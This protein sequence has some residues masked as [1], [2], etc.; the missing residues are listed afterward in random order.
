MSRVKSAALAAAP[1]LFVVLWS[2]GFIGTKG[3]ARNADPFAFLALRFTIAAG[4]MGLLTALLRAPWPTRGQ[5]GRAAVTG[6]LLH[7]GYLG[8]VT[9]AIWLGLPAGITSVLVGVQPLLT[10]G[11]SWPVLGERVTSRQWAGLALGFVGVL[12]VVEG[13]VGAGGSVGTGAVVAAL[14]ALACTTAGT[15]YQR[16]VGADMPLLG[17]TT[18]QYVAS[19]AALGLVT[20]A[21]GGG[22][23]HWTTEF[24]V[25]LTWL[26][27]VL[28]VGAILLLMTLLRDL[29]AARV[30]S[31]FYLVPPLA[32]LET[33]LLYGERLSAASLAGLALCVAGVA[34]AAAPQP[35]PALARTS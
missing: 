6:L 29:P 18:A 21:R 26:V 13:R 20:L 23:V 14:V 4:L 22:E 25:S 19:A 30:G 2:T 35:S 1:L 12:L 32:V 9:T 34:L 3:A 24:V 7:A 16:R 27:L 8:G 31:L 10:A 11:L 5:A 33:W 15:L 17:G 28:S